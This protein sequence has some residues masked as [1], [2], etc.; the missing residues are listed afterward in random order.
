MKSRT[1]SIA[2]V[3]CALAASSCSGSDETSSEDATDDTAAT[4]EAESTT[5]AAPTTAPTTTVEET[6]TTEQETTTTVEETTTTT[7]AP[8]PEAPPA[9]TGILTVG[10]EEFPFTVE[11]CNTEP[12]PG[13]SAGSIVLFEVRGP[14]TVEGQIGEARLFRLTVGNGTPNDSFG[15]GYTTDTSDFE[16]LRS[17]GSVF[18]LSD[19]IVVE[20]TDAGT[21]FYG[22]PTPFERTEGISV[23]DDV[24]PGMGSIIATC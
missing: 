15:W 22:P 10:D 5:T 12:A 20:Q 21:V 6:S 13:P 9:G 1:L 18:G 3:V 23:V 11:T 17:E 4:T 14:T 2:L 16:A 19:H 7:A 8:I 24:D